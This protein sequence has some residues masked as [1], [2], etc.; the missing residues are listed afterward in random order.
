LPDEALREV[1]FTAAPAGQTA[2]APVD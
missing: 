2:P 1:A